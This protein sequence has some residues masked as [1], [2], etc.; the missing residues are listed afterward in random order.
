MRR[1]RQQDRR[2]DRAWP[3]S[4]RSQPCWRLR[5]G[6]RQGELSCGKSSPTTPGMGSA[7]RPL[8]REAFTVS[9]G[10]ALVLILVGAAPDVRPCRRCCAGAP[11]AAL[12]GRAG[13]SA[14]CGFALY[15]GVGYGLLLMAGTPLD[16]RAE[17]HGSGR[18]RGSPQVSCSWP[19][20]WLLFLA[21]SIGVAYSAGCGCLARRRRRRVRS[22]IGQ[23][24]IARLELKPVAS[25]LRPRQRGRLRLAG[26]VGVDP[27]QPGQGSR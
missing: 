1:H 22:G 5:A 8:P 20:V 12:G 7:R 18:W 11:A 26:V 16:S 14:C 27:D 13:R 9:W 3:A 21:C 10:L 4:P 19:I 2:P 17:I 6:R 24:I 25:D 15:L 23:A